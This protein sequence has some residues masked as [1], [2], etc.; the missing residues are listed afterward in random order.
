MNRIG[1]LW[2]MDGVLVDTEDFHIEAWTRACRHFGIPFEDDFFHRTFGMNNRG[3]MTELL[4]REP[5]AG[6]VDEVGGLKEEYYR[7]SVRGRLLL[8]PGVGGLLERF[9]GEGALQAIASSGPRENI[10]L[11]VD[12]LDIGRHFK[13]LVSAAA[14]PGKPDPAVFLEAA[15]RIGVE[16]E[17]CLVIEDA[18]VGVEAAKRAGMACLAVETTHPASALQKA[19]RVVRTLDRLEMVSL[20][21]FLRA[22]TASVM[23]RK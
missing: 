9:S 23:S 8:L 22:L 17:N 7:D 20:A 1:V 21:E 5:S 11:I 2:D 19:D 6:Y 14:L 4:G 15:R 12:E 13:A 3:M 18:V 10:D 16:P